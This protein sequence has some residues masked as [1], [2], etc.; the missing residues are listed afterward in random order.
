MADD[1]PGKPGAARRAVLRTYR[2]LP[3]RVRLGLVH[4]LTPNYTIGAL[5]F[6]DHGGEYLMLR[7]HHRHGWTLPGGLV[8]PG[9]DA[10]TAA[11]REVAEET[12]LT[13]R[14][15]EPLTVVVDAHDRRA[16]VI[17]HVPVAARPAVQPRSEAV[18][19]RWLPPGGLGEVDRPTRQAFEALT[20]ALQ[21]GAQH[22]AVLGAE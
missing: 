7:Q 19:A 9:E 15:G 22:G 20:R 21:P 14:L 5:C 6:I 12:G 17:F 3:L 11:A 16:D 4:L 18:A 2:R 13:V 10:A 8:D 1:S